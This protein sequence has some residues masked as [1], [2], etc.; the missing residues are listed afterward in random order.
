MSIIALPR[1]KNSTF[2]L[3]PSLAKLRGLHP[4]QIRGKGQEIT[5]WSP[6]LVDL[7]QRAAVHWGVVSD[8]HGCDIL[9]VVNKEAI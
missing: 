8:L 3:F 5:A 9:Q 4:L 2:P 6:V 1:V 7:Y